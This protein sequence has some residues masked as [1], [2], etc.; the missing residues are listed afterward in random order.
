MENVS[1]LPVMAKHCKTCP[2]KCNDEGEWQDINLAS[3]VIQRNLFQ[4]QQICHGSEGKNRKA[5]HRCKGYFDYAFDIY[6]NLGMD[7]GKN[8]INNPK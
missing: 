5:T 3:T 8:L 4:S 2:F 7:P 1:E 6:E